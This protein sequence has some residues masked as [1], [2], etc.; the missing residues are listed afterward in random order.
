MRST[1]GV[2]QIRI[3]AVAAALLAIAPASTV[4]ATT[5]TPALSHLSAQ[6]VAPGGQPTGS[7]YFDVTRNAGSRYVGRLAIRNTSRKA[8]AV[9]LGAVDGTTSVTSGTVFPAR[10]VHPHA[11]GAWISLPTDALTIPAHAKVTVRFGVRVPTTAQPGD[12]VGGVIVEP[13]RAAHIDGA[14]SVTRIVRLAI[15]VRVRVRGTAH[16]ELGVG[17]PRL[18]RDADAAAT[19][20]LTAPLTGG[21]TLMCKPVLTATLS[22]HGA[23]VSAERRALDTVLPGAALDYEVRWG[24]PLADGTY[25]AEVRAEGCG[26]PVVSRAPVVLGGRAAADDHPTRTV[27]G[28]DAS[29]RPAQ[30]G[31]LAALLAIFGSVGWWLARGPL[32]ARRERAAALGPSAKS[33]R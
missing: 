13:V 19:P 14:A 21:G 9:H 16:A 7:P 8:V 23:I 12:H 17:A 18:G 3:A 20:V 15:A 2:V 33:S 32:R 26:T 5:P 11:A 1:Q 4:A 28:I 25:D 30:F 10:S 24:R 6:P 29:S 27:A 31:A 22:R